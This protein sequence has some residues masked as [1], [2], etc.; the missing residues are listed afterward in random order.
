MHVSKAGRDPPNQPDTTSAVALRLERTHTGHWTCISTRI[1]QTHN[2]SPMAY[3]GASGRV[4]SVI[5]RCN[6]LGYGLLI[7]RHRSE[8]RPTPFL[9]LVSTPLGLAGPRRSE[10]CFLK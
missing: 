8:V 9:P 7:R 5:P 6:R 2:L 1:L 3:L 4:R 10:C